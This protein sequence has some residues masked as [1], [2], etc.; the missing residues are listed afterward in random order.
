MRLPLRL[1]TVLVQIVII[2]LI[3]IGGGFAE[4]IGNNTTFETGPTCD[5]AQTGTVSVRVDHL[6]SFGTSTSYG[7]SAAFNP[8]GDVPDIGAKNTVYESMP[9]LCIGRNGEYSGEWLERGESGNLFAI[10]S[11]EDDTMTSE[12]IYDAIQVSHTSTFECNQLVQCWT[13]TNLGAAVDTLAITPYIDG[14]LYF[15]NSLNDFAGTSAGIPKT[16]YEYDEGSDPQAP[17]TQLALFGNDPTDQ[18]LT[19]W[20]IAEFDES[21]NRISNTSN[22]CAPL[23]GAI[24]DEFTRS[25]DLDGDLVTDTD[26]DVTLA[27]RFDAGPLA[28]NETSPEIC[29]TIRWGFALACSDEDEDGI[30]IPDDN[31]PSIPNPDQRDGDGDGA[32]DV[33]DLCPNAAD[34]INDQ[35]LALDSDQD[36]F[37][38][39]CDNCPSVANPDQRD[40]DRDGVGDACDLCPGTVDPDQRDSDRDGVGDACDNCALPNPDQIDENGDG[41]GDLCCSGDTEACNGI[42]DDCDGAIDEGISLGESSCS[43]G[44]PGECAA[45]VI[46]CSEGQVK[47][48][49]TTNPSE[50]SRCDGRDEDCDG[51]IDEGLRNTCSVCAHQ[52]DN[53]AELCNGEDD[54]CDG[55]IDESA[56]C[57]G[58]LTC[59]EGFCVDMCSNNECF[60]GRACVDGFCQSLCIG[61]VC[62]TGEA[63]NDQ[64]GACESLCETACPQN[65]ACDD[66]GEC[67]YNDCFGLGCPEGEICGIDGLCEADP[68]GA[69]QCPE[70]SFCREGACV[71]SCAL[72]SCPLNAVCVDGIC[73]ELPCWDEER[74]IG[75]AEG[76]RCSNE[77][78]CVPDECESVQCPRGYQCIEGICSG[79][80]CLRVSCPINQYCVVVEGSAQCALIDEVREGQVTEGG[81]DEAG[82]QAGNEAAGNNAGDVMVPEGGGFETPM[83][84]Q[85]GEVVIPSEE[86]SSRREPSGCHQA[87]R[88]PWTILA[89][90]FM[91]SILSGH[92]RSRR[93]N[94]TSRSY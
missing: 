75:C 49:P 68:C 14:D 7:N 23:R 40:S 76:Q 4:P 88:S 57:A 58:G 72:V 9:F 81:S 8:A 34:M 70:R 47:C 1:V 61:V 21:K 25:T 12:Y 84:P 6:G 82:V 85:G 16:I 20:E 50:E 28:P 42:D 91:L 30:C 67:V 79:D 18:F 29:Y 77:G 63:C 19:N 66:R 2:S 94:N 89:L 11:R 13:F 3:C 59:Q 22:G 73:Q 31:C 74:G 60:G 38:N 65:E 24:V 33:C 71:P 26:Y 93:H 10:A 35:G 86:G 52:Q 46:S 37:G 62:A 27:L 90:L 83:F 80:P 41:I 5:T 78:I 45:G 92:Q 48:L 87:Q 43:T 32:G 54:D 51:L 15:Q 53:R 44:Q 69:V 39:S 36:G 55:L 17:T 56:P 64:T